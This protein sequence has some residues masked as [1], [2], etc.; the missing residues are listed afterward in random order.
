MLKGKKIWQERDYWH[1]EA[2]TMSR[3]QLEALQWKRLHLQIH[4]IYE[5]STLHRKVWNEAGLCPD[6]I[7]SLEDFRDRA[8]FLYKDL[9]RQERERSGDPFGGM[10]CLPLDQVVV[11]SSSGT[12]GVPTFVGFTEEDVG[13]STES[14]AR[15]FWSQG[16]RPGD[17]Y[18]ACVI[19]WHPAMPSIKKVA[20]VMG[21]SVVNTELSPLDITRMVYTSHFLKPDV[22]LALPPPMISAVDEETARLGLDPKEVFSSYKAILGGGDIITRKQKN[23]AREKWGTKLY[24]VAGIGE[25]GFFPGE[26][27]VQDGQHVPEDLFLFEIVDPETS[28]PLSLTDRGEMVVSTLLNKGT[29]AVRWKSEDICYFKTERCECG[30]THARIFYLGRK[31]FIVKVNG[32]MVFPNDITLALEG[33]A[34]A[35]HGLFQII[36]YAEEM[37]DLQ[38]RVG[39]FPET[40]N[41]LK[42]IGDAITAAVEKNV[43]TKTKVNFVKAE[44]L[45]AYGPPHKIPRIYKA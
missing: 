31:G 11:Q 36:K 18:H 22:W 42:E 38:L 41:K 9:V 30:R 4:Y 17:L 35:E 34:G 2:E 44:E 1:P 12:T 26:C 33:I 39:Y 15:I 14:W 13:V 3:D 43:G 7:R 37:E 40:L 16:V 10:L 24:E 45:L 29:P 23:M 8:P 32:Q 21:L 27:A 25:L 6:D 5:N 19:N 28:R 20:D